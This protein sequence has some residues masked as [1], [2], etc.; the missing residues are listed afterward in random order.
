MRVIVI[1]AYDI[2][3]EKR[4]AKLRRYLARLGLGRVNRSV[5]AGPGSSSTAK[6]VAEK[7]R[8]IVEEGDSVFIIVVR[9]E[10]YQRALV[11]DGKDFYVVQERRFEVY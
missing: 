5:Y 3:D 2:G 4:R 6:L 10:S 7:T 11:F 1:V 8:K 9:E